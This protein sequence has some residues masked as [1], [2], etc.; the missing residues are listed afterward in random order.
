MPRKIALISERFGH[1]GGGEAIKGQ[2]Y[3]D[4]LLRQGQDVIVVTHER[5]I[6]S[7]GGR[8]PAERLRL[9][10]DT[11]LQRFFWR[12]KVLGGLIGLYFHWQA[13]R[14]LLTEA[15]AD[16]RPAG[17]TILHY[18]SPVS[19]VA[20]RFPPRGFDVVIGPM[21]GN[22]YY[23]PGFR[24]RMSTKDRI[25]ERFHA[26]S[27]RILRVLAPEKVRADV[28]LVSGYDRT[29]ASLR[30][31]GAR[32]AQMRDVVDAGVKDSIFARPRLQHAGIN[33]AFVC[34]GRMVD[35][36]GVDLAI[37]ALVQTKEPIR[38]DIFGDGPMRPELEG[39]VARLGL[40]S[41]VAFKGWMASHDALIAGF[42][43]YRGYVFPSLAEANGIV[44]QE[45]MAIGLPVIGLRWGGPAMLADDASAIYITPQDEAQVV[46]D[47][48]R[49][50]DRLAMDGAFADGIAARARAT[51]ERSFTWDAVAQSWQG[52][53]QTLG[54]SGR[55]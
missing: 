8:F 21:T 54:Q 15:A 38:L 39:L 40:G 33:T 47:I 18:I 55:A 22:I 32:D 41:R 10:P 44:M 36:K 20:L 42:A 24:A 37:K 25:R 14:L 6:G 50:M 1:S 2:Q 16:G 29:R 3:A 5:S 19:P 4:F 53:Y 49:A 28:L 43:A 13:R 7:L 30:M 35:H 23:P 52:S 46:A 17:W 45:A 12:S 27:Q 11:G 31:A 9:V 34:S 48:A 26:L 51:A